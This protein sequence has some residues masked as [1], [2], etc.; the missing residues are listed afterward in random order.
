[1]NTNVRRITITEG[2]R[3][4][5]IKKFGCSKGLISYALNYKRESSL[6]KAIR[7][8]ALRLGGEEVI[9]LPVAKCWEDEGMIM[10]RYYP[11]GVE[12]VVN[13]Q[14]FEI[15]LYKNGKQVG[16]VDDATF[17]DLLNVHNTAE[18]LSREL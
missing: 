8:E 4:A 15:V 7:M 16:T 6:S 14:F 1:M 2:I 18:R 3:D 11:N 9:T 12:L 10:R 5:I 13:K 17:V